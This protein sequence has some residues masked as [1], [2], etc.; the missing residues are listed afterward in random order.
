MICGAAPGDPADHRLPGPLPQRA[1]PRQR[2]GIEGRD[3]GARAATRAWPWSA[4][5][6]EKSRWLADFITATWEELDRPCSERAI[7]HA[8]TCAARRRASRRTAGA[9]SRR[10]ASVE[11]V[12]S[13]GRLQARRPGRPPHEG[14]PARQAAFWKKCD[15][16]DLVWQSGRCAVTCLEP[17]PDHQAEEPHVPQSSAM[18]HEA[19]AVGNCPIGPRAIC[20][21]G[22]RATPQIIGAGGLG[23]PIPR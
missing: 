13:G 18:F 2:A 17:L 14:G 1:R 11:C 15:P 5:R 16:A 8:I 23:L 7:D 4:G 20:G 9:C 3:G 22:I 6:R 12:A 10:R 21:A 19:L